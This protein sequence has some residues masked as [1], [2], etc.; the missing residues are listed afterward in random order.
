MGGTL[1]EEE[2]TVL[3]CLHMA[4]SDSLIVGTQVAERIV[5]PNNAVIDLTISY[6]TPGRQR[7]SSASLAFH[8]TTAMPPD[9]LGIDFPTLSTDDPSFRKSTK[10]D[11][12]VDIGL[13]PNSLGNALK[14]RFVSHMTDIQSEDVVYRRVDVQV[15]N[16]IVWDIKLAPANAPAADKD[17][18]DAVTKR[19]KRSKNTTVRINGNLSFNDLYRYKCGS[20]LVGKVSATTTIN[21]QALAFSLYGSGNDDV[22]DKQGRFLVS[23]TTITDR[24]AALANAKVAALYESLTTPFSIGVAPRIVSLIPVVRVQG[25]FREIVV[26]TLEGMRSVAGQRLRGL[27]S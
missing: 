15:F 6:E 4:F 5:I 22:M 3:F 10:D 25:R 12:V 27:S 13:S 17:G 14:E 11:T 26:A 8:V 21:P 23:G 1:G 7:L 16:P 24:R 18:V 19:R 20:G 9:G 2:N